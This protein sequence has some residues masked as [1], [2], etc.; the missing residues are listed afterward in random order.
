MQ[1][2][3]IQELTLFS[4]FSALVIAMTFIPFVG[5]ITLPGSLSITT[6]HIIVILGALYLNNVYYGLALGGVWGVTCLIYAYTNGT[7]DAVIFL[8]PRISVLPRILVGLLVVLFYKLAVLTAKNKITKY[9]LDFVSCGLTGVLAGLLL[10]NITSL[11]AIGISAALVVFVALFILFFFFKDKP[12]SAVIFAT[13]MGTLSNTTLVL[14]AITLFGSEGAVQIV[15]TLQTI[16]SVAI[17]LNGTLEL[18]AAVVIVVPCYL[19]LQKTF[20]GAHRK[21]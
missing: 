5:Y 14:F 2:E 10:K 13:V 15:G 17:S 16:F 3:K 1:K 21:Y 11:V 18:I 4:V 19:A 8:D 7:A 6:L 9:I 20:K 12:Y